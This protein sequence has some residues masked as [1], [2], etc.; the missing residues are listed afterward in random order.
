[1]RQQDFLRLARR[2]LGLTSAGLARLLGVSP[3]AVER[4]T[5][6]AS[7]REHRGMPLIAVRFIL[8]LLEAPR[9]AHLARGDR[10]CAEVIDAMAA[11]MDPAALAASLRTFDALQRSARRLAPSLPARP[12]PA[13][14][15]FAQKNAWERREEARN[16]R[17]AQ[18]QAAGRG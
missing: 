17:R 8:H 2:E 6:D 13:F 18:A 10:A 12:K 14:R 9:R 1:M 3:R 5:A 15:T 4:W 7:S 16:A 11:Q